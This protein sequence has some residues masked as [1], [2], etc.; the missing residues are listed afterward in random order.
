[1][2]GAVLLVLV[3]SGMSMMVEIEPSMHACTKHA[4]ERVG[5]EMQVRAWDNMGGSNQIPK[6]IFAFCAQGAVLEEK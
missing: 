2:T 3:Y 5:Q 6:V 4:H 1:M